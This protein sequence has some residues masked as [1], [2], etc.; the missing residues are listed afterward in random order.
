MES[1]LHHVSKSIPLLSTSMGL[2]LCSAYATFRHMFGQTGV[3]GW[4]RTSDDELLCRQLRSASP[5]RRH[6][7]L[8]DDTGVE[9]VFLGYGPSVLAVVLIIH[10]G[11]G[12]NRTCN[13]HG[14]EPCRRTIPSPPA[15][16]CSL[17]QSIAARPAP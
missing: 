8:V 16:L 11:G 6:K 5:P 17:I 15:M 2:L 1:P 4:I 7:L 14:Y 13:S 10:G 12:R 3:V 9:P